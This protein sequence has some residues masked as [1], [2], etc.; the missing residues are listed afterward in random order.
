[1]NFFCPVCGWRKTYRPQPKETCEPGKEAEYAS[2][3]A[4]VVGVPC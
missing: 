4:D 1:M 3:R 2:E